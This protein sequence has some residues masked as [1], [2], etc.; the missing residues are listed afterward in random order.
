MRR[1]LLSVFALDTSASTPLGHE[2][3]L[4]Y[5]LGIPALAIVISTRSSDVRVAQQVA[6]DA[7]PQVLTVAPEQDPRSVPWFAVVILLMRHKSA[8][9]TIALSIR[10]L[11]V[12][13]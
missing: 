3:V 6:R 10:G 13:L 1:S 7:D 4:L 9:G 8:G 11:P 2:H 12:R 5:M